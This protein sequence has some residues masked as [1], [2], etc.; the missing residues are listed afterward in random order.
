MKI[1]NPKTIRRLARVLE[2]IVK[3]WMRSTSFAYRPMTEYLMG[4]RPDLLG[5]K[6]CIYILWHENIF[7]PNYAYARP[8]TG[9]LIGQHADGEILAQVNER[10]GYSMIR[11][12]S[13]R[14]GTGA[15]LRLLRESSLRHFGITPDG[16]R[17]PRRVCQL[18]AIFLA[19]RLGIPLVSVGVGYHRAWRMRSW[20]RFAIPKLFSRI[21]IVTSHPIHVPA[22]LGSEELE[23]YRKMA[24][25][26]LNFVTKVAEHWAISGEFDSMGYV[27]PHGQEISNQVYPSA[28]MKGRRL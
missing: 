3:A 16:P 4:D 17:G 18:G 1:R 11:G 21:R 2:P 15:M 9:L 27:P 10:L 6:R 26:E 13:T 28:R 24:E 8:D 14:G 12:S 7:A 23:P 5:S 19:S 22:K 20:D 25:D